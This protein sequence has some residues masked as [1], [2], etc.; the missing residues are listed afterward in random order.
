MVSAGRSAANLNA[1]TA[2]AWS[3]WKAASAGNKAAQDAIAGLSQK[4]KADLLHN[5]PDDEPSK[6]I[7]SLFPKTKDD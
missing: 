3:L 1:R 2:A 6:F 7:R 4:E 5:L